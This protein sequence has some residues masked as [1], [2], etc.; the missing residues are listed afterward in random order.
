MPQRREGGGVEHQLHRMRGAE[1]AQR[2]QAQRVL[3]RI[4][5]QR[6][7]VQAFGRQRLGQRIEGGRV[8]RQQ[9]RAV[10]HQRHHR[11]AG[12]PARAQVVDAGHGRRG[13]QPRHVQRHLRQ[14]ARRQRLVAMAQAVEG[15]RAQELQRIGRPA[16]AQV[17]PQP[18]ADGARRGAAREQV[19]VLLQVAREDGELLAVPARELLELLQAVGPGRGRAQVVDHHHARMPQHL[20]RIEVERGR[21]AQVHEVGQPQRGIAGIAGGERAARGRQQGQRGVGRA[22]HHDL[23]RRL[24]EP[25]DDAR[26]VL[27]ETSG[28]GAQQVHRQAGSA[29]PSSTSRS[30]ASSRSSPMKTSCVRG[31]SPSRQRR[32]K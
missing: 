8:A 26:V 24:V 21:L 2:R 4:E 25:G 18:V 31:A 9:V 13:G 11:R 20:V 12:P 5:R 27:D 3:E 19:L 1:L 23:A 30:A 6:Q 10:E 16:R 14:A 29:A 28:L 22:E 15:H 32:S 17:L 7:R